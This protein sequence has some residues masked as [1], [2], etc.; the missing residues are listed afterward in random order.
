MRIV[1]HGEPIAQKRH[2][3]VGKRTYDPSSKDKKVVAKTLLAYKVGARKESRFKDSI[4]VEFVFFCKMPSTWSDKK[5]K[6]IEGKPRPK[7]PD[8][9][10]YIKFYLDCM[11]GLIFDDDNI[12]VQI[13]ARKLYSIKPCVLIYLQPYMEELNLC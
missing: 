13:K 3:H 11:S 6:E 8:I 12:V 1:I 10:N 7:K 2:R 4:S 5:K 9:D